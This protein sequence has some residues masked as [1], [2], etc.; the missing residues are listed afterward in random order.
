MPNENGD[1]SDTDD[2]LT[3]GEDDSLPTPSGQQAMSMDVEPSGVQT[4]AASQR[5]PRVQT[6][7]AEEMADGWQPAPT[8][9][10]RRGG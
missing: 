9:N 8:K 7:T 4:R 2:D 10:R 5:E 6:L 3:E 1:D